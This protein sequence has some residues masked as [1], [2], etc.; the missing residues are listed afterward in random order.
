MSKVLRT[1]AVVAAVVA[2]SFAIP[3]VG[4]AIGGAIGLSISAGTAATIAAVAS[5][6]SAVATAGA[7]ALQKPPDMRGTI[8]EVVIGANLP[9]P[10]VMGRTFVGGMKI[11][12]DAATNGSMPNSDRTQI[13]VGSHGGPIEG[14]EKFLADFSP[15]TFASESGGLISGVASGYYGDDGG[16]LW[17]NSRKGARPDTALTAPAGRVAFTGWTSD[18]KLSGMAAWS[19][20]ME[21]DEDGERWA[22]GIPDRE[23][24]V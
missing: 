12:D 6:V 22:G 7:Q 15:I 19:A 8:N 18:H 13:F 9:V 21:F 3:G 11:Y 24:V 4:T 20:T 14:F 2:I 5:A 23:S 1:V 16:Y 10:Y 17:L